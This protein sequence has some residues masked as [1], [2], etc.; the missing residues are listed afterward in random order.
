MFGFNNA[1]ETT[2]KLAYSVG[3]QSQAE[4]LAN[5]GVSMA[6]VKLANYGTSDSRSEFSTK[7]AT[8]NKGTVSYDA[9]QGSLPSD[10]RQISSTAT[11]TSAEGTVSYTA[12]AI[13][14]YNKGR[15]RVIRVY[16]E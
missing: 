1:D 9:T 12:T 3:Y 8:V 6:L 10:Q 13:V 7:T 5:T 11:V 4:Q 16:S 2:S 15:W 14:H